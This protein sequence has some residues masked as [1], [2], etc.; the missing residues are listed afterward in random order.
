MTNEMIIAQD[1]NHLLELIK[2]EIEKHGNEC[3]LN[4]INVSRIADMN[5]LFYMSKFNGNISQWNVSHVKNMR[6]MFDNSDFNGD[7]SDWN[8][9]NV[10]NMA[11]MFMNSAFNKDIS[12][13]NVSKVGHMHCMFENSQF[14]GD[15]NKWKPY[16]ALGMEELFFNTQIPIPY[17]ANYKDLDDRKR[18]IESYVERSKLLATLEEQLDV[19]TNGKRIKL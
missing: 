5:S 3:G 18:A 2:E 8:V 4:H 6:C 7:I 16:K 19:S 12:N 1:K 11:H 15:L 14:S 10:K 13:W 9:S 17:W